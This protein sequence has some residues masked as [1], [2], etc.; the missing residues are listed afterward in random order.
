MARRP[1]F[2]LAPEPEQLRRF[3]EA[4]PEPRAFWK[5]EPDEEINAAQKEGNSGSCE[6]QI[7]PKIITMGGCE[8]FMYMLTWRP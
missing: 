6:T 7:P 8:R 2:R 3:S 4:M 5:A 1:H